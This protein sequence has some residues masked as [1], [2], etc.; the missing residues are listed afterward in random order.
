MTKGIKKQTH[1][2]TKS[3]KSFKNFS[4]FEFFTKRC[5]TNHI[6]VITH[7][8]IINHRAFSSVNITEDVNIL[9]F[10]TSHITIIHN[11][12]PVNEENRNH[13]SNS[14]NKT[15]STNAVILA[16]AANQKNNHAIITYLRIS[17][18]SHDF[19]F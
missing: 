4:L 7:Q 15:K 12:R 17:F 19:L 8:I 13:I 18:L 6:N 14:P 2:I 3:L 1:K 16:K 10:L 5:V 11:Q 9:N